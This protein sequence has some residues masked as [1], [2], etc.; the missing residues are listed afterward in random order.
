MNFFKAP[1]LLK[2]FNRR[3]L[4][5]KKDELT[6]S[7]RVYLTFDDGPV[8][9][10]T[11]WV[12]DT[13]AQFDAQATFFCVGENVDRYPALYQE[14]LRRHHVVGNHTYHH[15]NAW[16]T[17][18]VTYQQDIDRCAQ[19]LQEHHPLLKKPSALFRPP[20]GKV[21][22]RQIRQLT[23]HYTL[24]MWDI[25]SGDYDANFSAETCWR[26]CVRHTQPGTIIIFHDS[27]KAKRNLTYVLPRYL[28][29][30]AQAGYTF[31]TL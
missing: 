2:R 17:D 20:Y 18:A 12:W 13:L 30:F 16:R 22:F 10:V 27:L 21:R 26:K 4:W 7:P 28:E 14:T 6:A 9:E 3:L 11:P 15:L 25:L 1:A 5:D 8:P 19:A 24:V 23:T 31:T 29:H